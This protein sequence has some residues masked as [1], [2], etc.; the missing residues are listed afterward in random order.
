[1]DEMKT[2]AA[3]D[4]LVEDFMKPRCK[5]KPGDRIYRKHKTMT[6]PD[7]LEVVEVTP[8]KT[9]YFIKCKYMYHGIGVQERTF[10][11]VIFQDDSWVIE[12]KGIDF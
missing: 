5:V 2:V 9:G 6:I 8:A 7:R 1:M 12:K 4:I 10:S 3:N 11:D